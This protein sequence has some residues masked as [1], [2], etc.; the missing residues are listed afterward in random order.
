MRAFV[1]LC[2]DLDGLTATNDRRAVM[3]QY[4]REAPSADIAW[5]IFFLSGR[6]LKGAFSSNKLRLWFL[7]SYPLPE[8]LFEESYSHVGDTAEAIS[9]L[10]PPFEGLPKVDRPLSDWMTNDLLPLISADD[11]TRRAK[12]TAWWKEY[13]TDT[14]F[15][16][17]KILTGA[18]RLGVSQRLVTDSLAT[19]FKVSVASLNRKLMGNWDATPEFVDQLRAEDFSHAEPSQPY[20]FFLAAP[21]ERPLASLGEPGEWSLEWKWDGIRGQVIRRAGETYIWS[22]GEELVTDRFPELHADCAHLP[23]GTVLDGEIVAWA[24]NKPKPFHELQRRIG[25]KKLDKAILDDVPV[26][27]IVYDLLESEGEDRRA[28]P[29]ARRRERLDLILTAH[30]YTNFH[31]APA[32]PFGAWTDAEALRLTA[33]EFNAE[34]LMIKRLS[35]AYGEGRRREDWWKF[36]LDPYTCD[37]VLLYAQAGSGRRSNLHTD[38]TFA[39][40]NGEE[41]VP[42]AKAYSGL[43]QKEIEDLDRWVRRNTIEKYG[44]VRSVKPELVF[45][46]GFE[47]IGPST[48]H[49]SGV[50]VRFPRI[51]RWRHDKPVAEADTLDNLRKLIDANA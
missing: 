23:D 19:A 21:L 41:L 13:P 39:V 17:N 30:A 32:L 43:D 46:L 4:F 45:E 16:L 31:P 11:D 27:F 51:L 36:K 2:R 7:A 9:L 3:A 14:V 1:N 38:Y 47:G 6:R 35:S 22:R 8:W 28:E 40:W 5:T 26:H 12:V 24:G 50:A 48:R 33:R 44:P 10:L 25:R 49:K 20:P 34:G 42:V 29:L 37:A 15:V 18:F